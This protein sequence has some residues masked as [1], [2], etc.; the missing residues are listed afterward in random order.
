MFT[1]PAFA[2]RSVQPP[3]GPGRDAATGA[4]HLFF[5]DLGAFDVDV[6]EVKCTAATSRCAF[7]DICDEGPFNDTVFKAQLVGLTPL[8][9]KGHTSEAFN[10]AGA[11]NLS[12]TFLCR[13]T[14]GPLSALAI[15]A[16]DNHAGG[17]DYSTL[18]DCRNLSGFSVNHTV[19]KKQDE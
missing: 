18:I 10:A 5:D 2:D 3:Q 15:F 8:A 14:N 6:Y 16:E 1:A 11:C 19:T 13:G 7:I 9:I 4:E 12:G 17:E